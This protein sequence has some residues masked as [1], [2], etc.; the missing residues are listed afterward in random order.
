[1]PSWPPGGASASTSMAT[2]S[3]LGWDLGGVRLDGVAG[4]REQ[5]SRLPNTYTGTVPVSEDGEAMS[6]FDASR[7]DDRETTQVELR[8]SSNSDGALDWVLGGFYQT[9]DDVFCV[10]QVLGFLEMV[11]QPFDANSSP[12]ILCNKQR[13]RG[14]CRLRR[15]HLAG[16]RQAD[17]RRRPALDRRDQGMDRP[18]AGARHCSSR[19]GTTGMTS[20]SHSISRISAGPT[21]RAMPGWSPTKSPGRSRR[22]PRASA[23]SSARTSTA[24]CATTEASRAEATTTRPAQRA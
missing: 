23:T 16:D 19:V 17:A 10:A 14:L 2:S 8:L 1:M 5:E 11:G 3:I 18:A 4:Y 6:L 7:D 13:R 15:R 24:T 12:F 21:G 22:I 20:A 9:N